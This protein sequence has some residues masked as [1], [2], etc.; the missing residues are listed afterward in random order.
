[1][2]KMDDVNVGGWGSGRMLAVGIVCRLPRSA[3]RVS[4][5]SDEI[6]TL[7]DARRPI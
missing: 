2:M 3:S 4:S 5:R 7:R 1:M 6:N